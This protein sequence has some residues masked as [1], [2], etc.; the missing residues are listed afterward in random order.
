MNYM[1]MIEGIT[2]TLF[3]KKEIGRDGFHRPIYEE[4]PVDVE[5]VLVYPASANDITDALNLTGKK[6]VYTL[7]IPKEDHHV[8]EDKRVE[9]FGESWHTL[10]FSTKGID[11]LIPL[12]WNRKVTVERYG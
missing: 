1:A 4:I 5:N 11:N 6:A 7:G 9:F 2:V 12:E 10:G 3:E 8:W